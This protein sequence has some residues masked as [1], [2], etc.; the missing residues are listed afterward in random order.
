MY[1]AGSDYALQVMET[2]QSRAT[3]LLLIVIAASVVVIAAILIG[4]LL[5]GGESDAHKQARD[6][7][8]REAEIYCTLGATGTLDSPT[9]K[10]CVK[11]EVSDAMEAWE[12]SH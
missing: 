4:P 3:M 1:L 8:T 6:A 7:A 5:G 11:R 10:N 9:Y 2:K 12:R